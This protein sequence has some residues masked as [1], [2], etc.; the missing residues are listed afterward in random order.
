[1]T[2]K[3]LAVVACCSRA[4]TSSPL[5]CESSLVSSWIARSA[6]ARS[7][8]GEAVMTTRPHLARKNGLVARL[9]QIAVGR[10]LRNTV[11]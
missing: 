6:E 9:A 11:A 4:S 8:V 3:I 10:M 5:A 7:S 1:M 2:L